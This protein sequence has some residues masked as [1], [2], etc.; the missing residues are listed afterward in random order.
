[1]DERD[2]QD[3][4]IVDA[5]KE[6]I[7]DVFGGTTEDAAVNTPEL[8]GSQMDMDQHELQDIGMTTTDVRSAPYGDSAGSHAAPDNEIPSGGTPTSSTP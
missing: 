4:G 3:K 7:S 5:A 1:M 8:V 2:G 6:A